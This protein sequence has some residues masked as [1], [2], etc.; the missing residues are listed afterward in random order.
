MKKHE[1]RD[2]PGYIL[3]ITALLISLTGILYPLKGNS[4][5]RQAIRN[6]VRDQMTQYPES[7]LQDIYKSF[8]QDEFGP[9]HLVSDIAGSGKYFEREISEMT[10]RGNYQAELCGT[11]KNFVRVPLDLV[12]DGKVPS[13]VYFDIFV[14]S[15]KSFK[16]P[17]VI[18]WKK[19]W[20]RIARIISAMGLPI[21]GFGNDRILLENML[22]H[23]DY[24]VHHSEA[25]L[26]AY[27]PHYRIISRK[28]WEKLGE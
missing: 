12:K 14:E 3:L 13:E 2:Y 5:C 22:Q 9:G 7:T 21:S 10:S 25:Y 15:A 23:G 8:F 24:V 28:E 6:A 17:D 19:R 18:R 1:M 16:I 20:T 4:Q 27:D 26:R 11:G